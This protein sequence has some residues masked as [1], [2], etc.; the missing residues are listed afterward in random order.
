MG[1]GMRI[2]RMVSKLYGKP[3]WGVRPGF[4]SFLTMEF[5]NPRLQVREPIVASKITPPIVR[6]S[7]A[8]RRVHIY[9]EWHLWIYCC[10]WGVFSAR[11]L[12][13]DCSTKVKIRRAAEFLDGQ[14]LTY[15]SISPRKV[16]CVFQF[17]LG[18]ILKTKPY[19]NE[20]EQWMLYEP[21][22]RVLS[23]RADGR[24]KY[25]PSDVPDDQG[26]W[27]RIYK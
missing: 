27:K 7:L 3:C 22:H 23:V 2:E 14:Q 24:Y 9:G 26:Q 11:S 5:G 8:R 4:G 10:D 6:K 15:F 18:A 13:G 21:S 20:S 12:V 1:E 25:G 16:S 19:D 17:D